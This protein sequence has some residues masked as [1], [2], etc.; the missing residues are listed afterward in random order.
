M[1]HLKSG[2]KLRRSPSHRKSLLRNLTASLI[3]KNRIETT[4]TK[5]KAIRPIVEKMI[6]MGKSG[7]IADK[8]RAMAFLYK[9]KTVK[10]LFDEL[11]PRFMDRAG[12]YTRIIHTD[13]RRKGDGAEMAIL[14]F[15][16]YIFQPKAKKS[17]E[18]EKA[19]K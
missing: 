14:E 12:G 3:E 15:T 11:A 19:K 2:F 5:A 10:V 8:R 16:D 4:L 17:K 6:T 7:T 13:W 1:R 18:K 9:R